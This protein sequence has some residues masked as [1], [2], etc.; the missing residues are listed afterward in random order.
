MLSLEAEW[1]QP[2]HL[3]P[4]RGTKT[5]APG[6]RRRHRR[7]QTR[8]LQP[9]QGPRTCR[10]PHQPA[11]TWTRARLPVGLKLMAA[12]LLQD[13][14]CGSRILLCKQEPARAMRA[15]LLEPE[16]DTTLVCFDFQGRGLVEAAGRPR[17]ARRLIG[18]RRP[19]VDEKNPPPCGCLALFAKAA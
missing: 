13:P 1:N 3:P 5:T 16:P 4:K 11:G 7:A 15:Q 14:A 19:S 17:A 6:V 9:C 2:W 18:T 10:T 12:S 8:P